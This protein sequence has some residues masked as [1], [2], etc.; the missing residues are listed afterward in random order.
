MA[1]N[2]AVREKKTSAG[3]FR[4]RWTLCH[5]RGG[6]KFPVRR[7]NLVY[8]SKLR[9]GIIKRSNLAG[10]GKGRGV[11]GLSGCGREEL[12]EEQPS[13]LTNRYDAQERQTEK[14]KEETG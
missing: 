10:K 3:E 2:T 6:G 8:F 13:G 9:A 12:D 11:G 4:I 7:K 5:R 14:K 1:Q